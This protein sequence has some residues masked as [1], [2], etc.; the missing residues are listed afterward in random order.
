MV[1]SLTMSNVLL[2]GIGEEKTKNEIL[3]Y[4]QKGSWTIFSA[5]SHK[6]AIEII[7]NKEIDLV[8]AG[9][10]LPKSNSLELLDILSTENDSLP[11]VIISGRADLKDAI[12]AIKKGASDFL[13]TPF[14]QLEFK[15]AVAKA[16]ENKKLI[17]E[18]IR[19]KRA[20]KEYIKSKL[21]GTSSAFQKVLKQI[22]QVAPTRSTV[23]IIGESGTGKELIA[24]AVH[25]LSLRVGKP[26]IKVNCGALSESLLE[27]ELFGHEKG[28]FTG[29]LTQRKGRFELADKGTLFLDEVSEM[30]LS[31]QVKLLRVLETGE[32]ERVGGSKTIKVDVRIIAATNRSLDEMV[33]AG[34]FREDLYYRLNVFTIEVPPLRERIEDIP[35]LAQYFI[36]HFAKENQ[37]NIMGFTPEVEKILISY[38]W[39]GNVREL[40]NI[41]ERA[42]ILAKGP[43]IQPEDLPSKLRF[44][45]DPPDLISIPIGFTMDEIEKEVIRKILLY[46][47]G[48]KVLA[49][50]ILGIGL[51]TLY[52]KLNQIT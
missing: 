10:R 36:Q 35:L 29:A 34:S 45:Q 42:V 46:T 44:I 13:V 2:I 25:N 22:Q 40:K 49:A 5:S 19:L 11:I 24:E 32:F 14:K 20:L 37:K 6:K 21:I 1:T 31:M 41:M 12:N 50:K 52:R 8:I 9:H 33:S 48:N 30:P 16:L 23:L 4:L 15:K 51:T 18:N 3:N 26:F 17:D 43:Y 27:S 47:K 38:H 7:R 28:A 39:P